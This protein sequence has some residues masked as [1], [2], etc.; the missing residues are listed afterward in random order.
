MLLQTG[1]RLDKALY[2]MFVYYVRHRNEVKEATRKTENFSNFKWDF[3]DTTR[4][5][6]GKI[7]WRTAVT[8]PAVLVEHYEL[9]D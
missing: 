2:E 1:K 8:R 5:A 4:L 7:T 6:Q 3:L 9:N